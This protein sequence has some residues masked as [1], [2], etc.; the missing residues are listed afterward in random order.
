[1]DDVR[2]TQGEVDEATAYFNL[3]TLLGKS[4]QAAAFAVT[5]PDYNP[6]RI[7]WLDRPPVPPEE[8]EDEGED[9][10]EIEAED[11]APVE[12]LHDSAAPADRQIIYSG[13]GSIDD[14][15][16]QL[17]AMYTP[18]LW[19]FIRKSSLPLMFHLACDQFSFEMTD[20]GQEMGPADKR[21]AALAWVIVKRVFALR[22]PDESVY[23][24]SATES[25]IRENPNIQF[26]PLD[27]TDRLFIVETCGI[28][29]KIL[30]KNMP[31]PDM[32][33][34]MAE[35]MK[36]AQR[37]ESVGRLAP[38]GSVPNGDA[39]GWLYRVVSNGSRL[40]HS[41]GNRHESIIEQRKGN[42]V[43]YTRTNKQNGSTFTVG[44]AQADKYLLK[45]NKT[46]KKLLLFSLQ[47]LAAQNEPVE[48]GFSLQEL[49]DLGMY[50]T[51]SN[52]IRGIKEFFAQQKQTTI[53]GTFQKGRKTIREEGGILFYHY[54]IENGY[55]KLS[56]NEN[57]NLDFITNYYTV[58]PRFA[59]ALSINAFSLVRYIFFLARQN[60][61]PI[62]DKGKF[63]ISLD[64]VRENL[65][66]PAPEDV[67][68]RRYRQLIIEPIEQA[69][70]E[71]EN[72]LQTVPEA[73]N[74]GFTITPVVSDTGNIN[75]WLEGYLE[76]GL[77]DD[78]AETFIRL[79]AKKEAQRE[80]WTKL[81]SA[82][83][84]K[85]AAKKEASE[86]E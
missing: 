14:Q 83:F 84:A 39:L 80:K 8:D 7:V 21:K 62:R 36:R 75:Q 6:E 35:E 79:A 57:F 50:S 12:Q 2:L 78:F 27:D 4:I 24:V 72:A 71:I 82:E 42:E 25:G 28:C 49:V 47:K 11:T 46:F 13:E 29:E 16:E 20:P 30:A 44:F 18:G 60:T 81:K 17:I 45:T 55:V 26:R 66:L 3:A 5:H 73:K 85:L 43:R 38:L 48:V 15:I 31:L 19:E 34:S 51:T 86:K 68:N 33:A 67:K 54:H 61:Q 56:I 32:L 58:F 22:H 41:N 40:R 59:Y 70:E 9:D 63:T 1:M 77:K 69:I 64:A 76:I 53:S 10:D 37:A 74:Y 65:G 23:I 52:A